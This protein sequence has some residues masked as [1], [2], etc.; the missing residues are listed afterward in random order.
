MS[1]VGEK[2]RDDLL[3]AGYLLGLAVVFGLI[4][5]WPLVKVA[6]QGNLEAHL[7]K[8]QNERRAM[9][10]KGIPTVN[11]EEAHDLWQQGKTLFID[12]RSAEEFAELH[13]ARAVNVPEEK[14]DYPQEL[15]EAGILGLPRDRQI[16]VYCSTVRCD[17][18]L[19]AARR[20][21]SLGF[22]K[23][24]AFLGGFQAWDEAG[25]EVDSSL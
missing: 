14:L 4:Y 20:L 15:K 16:L 10:F 12:V 1:R 25:Y 13:V 3:W 23:V 5:H 19:K 18:S 24:M 22:T 7:E 6:W 9:E 21:R 8:L 17:A 2:F 11:L